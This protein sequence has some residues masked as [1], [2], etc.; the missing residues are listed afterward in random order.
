MK[1][2]LAALLCLASLAA[3][4][5]TIWRC[6]PDGHSYSDT[7]CKEGRAVEAPLPRPAEDVAA[8]RAT[9]EREQ[10]L[11]DRLLAERR[12]REAAQPAGAAGIRDARLDRAQLKQPVS[13]KPQ[14]PQRIQR[15]Q[16]QQP[17]DDGTWRAVV[18]VSRR[19]PG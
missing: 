4:S 19:T 11:A 10:E 9:A 12:Q 6:G 17:E 5:Q 15:L 2:L 13:K 18:P 16:Q 3:Q 7:P 1:T 8:A 14:R